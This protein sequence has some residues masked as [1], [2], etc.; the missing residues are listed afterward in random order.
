MDLSLQF[1]HELNKGS[2]NLVKDW[3]DLRHTDNIC[4][5][6]LT[7][8]V[9]TAISNFLQRLEFQVRYPSLY[10]CNACKQL[11]FRYL[12]LLGGQYTTYR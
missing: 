12:F 2:T 6:D 4:S 3:I 1:I 9:S 8:E 5:G 11:T 7:P 10:N